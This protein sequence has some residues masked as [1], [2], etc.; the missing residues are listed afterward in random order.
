M[1]VRTAF[2]TTLL[3]S[4]V[5]LV[6]GIGLAARIESDNFVPIECGQR[7]QARI[8]AYA[9]VLRLTKNEMSAPFGEP[10]EL[11]AERAARAW[12]AGIRS[13]ELQPLEPVCIADTALD[14]ARGQVVSIELTMLASLVV[15]AGKL[16]AQGHS[17]DA[18]NVCLTGFEACQ[19]LKYS[20]FVSLG[21]MSMEERRFLDVLA[22]SPV[23]DA[24]L[25]RE[26]RERIGSVL[27]A[28]ASLTQIADRYEVQYVAEL[29]RRGIP[30]PAVQ[31]AKA[32]L[33]LTIFEINTDLPALNIDGRAFPILVSDRRNDG[34]C[35]RMGST[36]WHAYREYAI[37]RGQ[38]IELLAGLS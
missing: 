1:V 7:E 10:R 20:D 11:G 4:P 28:P 21:M 5:I 24:R 31:A 19:A 26:I 32:Q 36:A 14:G 23:T 17:A 30:L 12:I 29:Q 25:K 18:V 16:Q 27:A 34:E 33:T 37:A 22:K 9:P 38:A 35:E 2:F 13:G 15:R 3:L 8:D 6:A